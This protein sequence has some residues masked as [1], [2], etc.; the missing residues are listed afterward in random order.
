MATCTT[1]PEERTESLRAFTPD[2]ESYETARTG[3]RI[4][5]MIFAFF[6]AM[7]S[8]ALIV[9]SDAVLQALAIKQP[10]A[11]D[12]CRAALLWVAFAAAQSTWHARCA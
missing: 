1:L 9:A 8:A 10:A 7:V 12:F 5:L 4:E 2:F 6:A 11:Y 3:T